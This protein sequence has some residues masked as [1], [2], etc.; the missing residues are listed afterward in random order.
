MFSS[1][2]FTTLPIIAAWYMSGKYDINEIRAC[3]YNAGEFV[4]R[5]L[6]CVPGW[7]EVVE[8]MLISQVARVF[9]FAHAFTEGLTSDNT[10][11]VQVKTAMQTMHEDVMTELVESSAGRGI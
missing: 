1:P 3:A 10:N 11:R 4:S 5:H 6:S 2:D 9:V 7:D 8:P